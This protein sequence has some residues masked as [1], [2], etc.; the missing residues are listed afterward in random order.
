MRK[1]ILYLP[2]IGIM[3]ISA[4]KK[5]DKKDAVST[6]TTLKIKPDML[7][8]DNDGVRVWLFASE[9]DY[10]NLTNPIREAYSEGDNPVVFTGLEQKIYYFQCFKQ[11]PGTGFGAAANNFCDPSI[12]VYKTNGSLSPSQIQEIEVQMCY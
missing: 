9:S 10:Q 8:C 2:L 7:V 3:L 6:E 1:A 11:C 4:C 12:E 5:E